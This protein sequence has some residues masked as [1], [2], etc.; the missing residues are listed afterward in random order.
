MGLNIGV[1][2]SWLMRLII[3]SGEISKKLLTEL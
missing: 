2:V 1:P 3:R